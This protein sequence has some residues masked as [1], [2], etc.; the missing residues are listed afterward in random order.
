MY[1][2]PPRPAEREYQIYIG[3]IR[4]LHHNEYLG[5]G[6]GAFRPPCAWAIIR[7]MQ[8]FSQIQCLWLS[9]SINTCYYSFR[10][11]KPFIYF[12]AGIYI[13]YNC[14]TLIPRPKRYTTI[15]KHLDWSVYSI[16]PCDINKKIFLN[17]RTSMKLFGYSIFPLGFHN[18]KFMKHLYEKKLRLNI[19]FS[20]LT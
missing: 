15:Y 11:L 13:Q 14:I 20:L 10:I 6:V 3:L 8:S 1:L 7:V 17:E 5:E 18:Q 19:V 2:T 9:A 4:W 16:I 12:C